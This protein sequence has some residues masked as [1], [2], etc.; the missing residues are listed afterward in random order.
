MDSMPVNRGYFQ[1][2]TYGDLAL[3]VGGYENGAGETDN[4]G[5][6][7]NHWRRTDMWREETGW[8]QKADHPQS[9]G[10]YLVILLD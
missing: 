3:A 7:T 4:D 9:K 10:V 1:L 2:A 6:R 8:V 5:H